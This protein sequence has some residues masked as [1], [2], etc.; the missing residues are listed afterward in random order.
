MCVT[1]LYIFFFAL[2]SLFNIPRSGAISGEDLI[3]KDENSR[4]PCCLLSDKPMN[5]S[6]AYNY[7]HCRQG[8]LLNSIHPSPLNMS[9]AQVA[10]LLENQNNPLWS[11]FH[12]RQQR[13]LADN[14]PMANSL[15][16]FES[17]GD[18]TKIRGECVQ[19]LYK[20]GVC[21]RNSERSGDRSR[22]E[23]CSGSL[24]REFASCNLKLHFICVFENAVAT[25]KEAA[26][27]RQP[28]IEV[29]SE[30]LII[31]SVK[32][33]EYLVHKPNDYK[34]TTV[35]FKKK[36]QHNL[37]IKCVVPKTGQLN[38][39]L[40]APV[41][42][43][44]GVPLATTRVHDSGQDYW[45][46]TEPVFTYGFVHFFRCDVFDPSSN[47]VLQSPPALVRF[48]D[49]VVFSVHINFSSPDGELSWQ[50]LQLSLL[51]SLQ[52]FINFSKQF[53]K[54]H[55]WLQVIFL[56][57][58]N[59]MPL[60][61]RPVIFVP[62]SE[63]TQAKFVILVVHDSIKIDTLL[64]DIDAPKKEIIQAF[65]AIQNVVPEL[66][67]STLT[68]NDVHQCWPTSD[69][70]RPLNKICSVVPPDNQPMFS[71]KCEKDKLTEA[72]TGCNNSQTTDSS[73]QLSCS[74][75]HI[76]NE[77][78]PVANFSSIIN[79]IKNMTLSRTESLEAENISTFAD[80]FD[81]SSKYD[82]LPD[83]AVQNCLDI[84]DT[85]SRS[86]EANL[87]QAQ[88]ESSSTQKILQRLESLGTQVEL[89]NDHQKFVSST[90]A[91]EV[92]NLTHGGNLSQTIGIKITNSLLKD[93]RTEDVSIIKSEDVGFEPVLAAISLQ[94]EFV[95]SLTTEPKRPDIKLVMRAHTNTRLFE[96][97]S[98]S[99]SNQT[100]SSMNGRINS[101]VMSM[102][103][104]V[105]QQRQTDL[106]P[107]YVT[108]SFSP[109]E[110]IPDEQTSIKSICVYWNF[111]ANQNTGGWSSDG[112]YYNRTEKGIAICKCS[113][114]TNFAMLLSYYEQDD[115]KDVHNL[116]L[117]IISI[118]GL[119]LSIFGLSLTI[120]S[121]L[122]IKS[123]RVGLPQKLLFQLSLS[124]LLSWIVFLAGFQQTSSHVGCLAVAALLHY[125]ILASFMWMLG[126]GILQHM[127]I[128]Q[129]LKAVSSKFITVYT[130]IAWGAPTIPVVVVLA[131]DT[132][133][134]K[135]G[136]NYCWMK[137]KALYYSFALPVGLIVVT[138]SIIFIRV[139]IRLHMRGRVGE[140][141]KREGKHEM[142]HRKQT[143]VNVRA[144]ITS[145]CILGLSW[146]FGFFA[147]GEA[148]V[149]FQYLFCILTSI[150]G[151]LI[152]AMMVARNHKF[153]QY[154]RS[155]FFCCFR[156]ISNLTTD[157]RKF[158]VNRDRLL[159]SE[160]SNNSAMTTSSTETRNVDVTSQ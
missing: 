146:T 32:N 157:S 63:N 75:Q 134:Y 41:I 131:I 53:T 109:L 147:V 148:R 39:H 13:L 36:T 21:R 144:S 72:K 11:G 156:R 12:I 136:D 60:N 100:P 92:W 110:N 112:C 17:D 79:G 48:Q 82:T 31:D 139:I 3:C 43:N 119:G 140:R 23:A 62:Q 103:L 74:S 78:I 155:V 149:Y 145:F 65:K 97:T 115:T 116:V 67:A 28:Q 91:L 95:T 38:T 61:M 6:E 89:Q 2:I 106:D 81:R 7:C 125:L 133:L 71:S 5:W 153:Q 64:K 77:S 14:F 44:F 18:S 90:M 33:G 130:L 118:V 107:Y 50:L 66:N 151:F 80:I 114:L 127:L 70:D 8:W 27:T 96:V 57:R 154:W 142:E 122:L 52:D 20:K 30:S 150:Q 49:D 152:F 9:A 124:L 47:T 102:Q 121:F 76:Q 24:R 54:A 40:Q 69:K 99:R 34:V 55:D 126:Q 160:S 111:S 113:H 120:V 68:L 45:N 158:I 83:S 73:E 93:L 123:L 86:P 51:G 128:V 141:V 1:N 10:Q 25:S 94:E 117:A 137:P 129:V 4:R 22:R 138:N 35:R 37:T 85:I 15:G 46:V 84:I 42:Y 88:E 159:M 16:D 59:A 104:F 58:D 105:N 143:I 98:Q 26:G 19:M 56:R 101:V 87:K 135:G 29:S 132:E 108:L